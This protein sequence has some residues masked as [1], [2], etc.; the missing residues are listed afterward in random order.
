[1]SL[2]QGS[3]QPTH[4][5]QTTKVAKS[6]ALTAVLLRIQKA[7]QLFKMLRTI[8]PMTQHNIPEDLN[9]HSEMFMTKCAGNNFNDHHPH[10]PHPH[11]SSEF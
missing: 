6:V 11:P 9:H 4:S 1:M 5:P 2:Q 10:T 8:Q 3:I 7:L